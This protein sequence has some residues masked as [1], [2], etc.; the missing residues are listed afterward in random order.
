M[1]LGY[2]QEF[3]VHQYE[4]ADT[5]A[6]NTTIAFFTLWWTPGRATEVTLARASIR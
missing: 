5:P 6:N 1:G 2:S 3:K 4:V